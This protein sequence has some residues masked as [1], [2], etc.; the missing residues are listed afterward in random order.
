MPGLPFA[1]VSSSNN[2]VTSI[3]LRS[4]APPS[5][6]QLS[7]RYYKIH[8]DEIRNRLNDARE[9]GKP[10][11]EE[12]FKGLEI[13]GKERLEDVVRWEQWEARGGLKKVNQPPHIKPTAMG[14]SAAIGIKPDSKKTGAHSDRST[15]QGLRLPP[16]P[17][18]DSDGPVMVTPVALPNIPTSLTCKSTIFC[19][20][21]RMFVSEP[22]DLASFQPSWI[23][24]ASYSENILQRHPAPFQTRPERS[25]REVNEAKANRRLEI[26]R[27]CGALDPPLLTNVLT[28][29]EAF[30]AAIQISQPLNDQAWHVLKPRLL[31]QRAYAERRE[32][33]RAAQNQLAQAEQKQRRLQE[34]QLKE[35]RE[36]LDREWESIQIPIRTQITRLAEERI[37]TKWA[38]GK[39]VTKDNCPKFA[40]DVLL[41]V[42]QKFY[43]EIGQEDEA[44]ITVSETTRSDAAD[45]SASRMLILENMKWLF[46]SQ[47]KPLTENFQKELFLCNGCDGN[48][49]FYGLESVVQH[50]AAKHTTSLS[51]GN[52]VV[53][54][55]A[56]WPEHPPFHPEPSVAKAAYYKIP[57][58]LITSLQGPPSRDPELA[59]HFG[60]FGQRASQELNGMPHF[61]TEPYKG[62]YK[63]LYVEQQEQ[64]SRNYSP[65][66][67][68]DYPYFSTTESQSQGFY[69]NPNF[70]HVHP[71][72]Q[73]SHNGVI[74]NHGM[75][76]SGPDY[77]SQTYNPQFS[78]PTY[79]ESLDPPDQKSLSW[80]GSE[81]SA[82]QHAPMPIP[83]RYPNLPL[84][85]TNSTIPY[86]ESTQIQPSEIY[87]HQVEEMARHARD[88]WSATS[89]IK[90]IP[91]SVR[92]FV[93]IHETVYRFK[94]TFL[95][96]PNLAMFIDGLDNN[97]LMRPIRS[98]KGL[99]CKV[100]VTSGGATGVGQFSYT[101]LPVGYRSLHTLPELLN[102]FKTAHVE[103]SR[104]PFDNLNSIKSQSPGTDWK[105][106]MIELPESRLITDLIT[107]PGM[108]DT[109]LE[110]LAKIFPA[111]FP[112][113]LPRMLSAGNAG[114]VPLYTG[115]L[116]SRGRPLQVLM[117]EAYS[118][119]PSRA[120]HQYENQPIPRPYSS[121]RESSQRTRSSEPPGE[122]E[123]DPHRPADLGKIVPLGLPSTH[124]RKSM[125]TSPAVDGQ[126]GKSVPPHHN[127]PYTSSGIAD[128]L[129]PSRTADPLTTFAD[130]EGSK[131]HKKQEEG[132]HHSLSLEG[133][134]ETLSED[135]YD[136]RLHDHR[137]QQK[138]GE[139]EG[140][141]N[142][143]RSAAYSLI[144]E[145]NDLGESLVSVKPEERAVSPQEGASAADEFLDNLASA[146][147]L[148]HTRDYTPADREEN[149]SAVKPTEPSPGRQWHRHN[150]VA[151]EDR[152]GRIGSLNR[153]RR[154]TD[155]PSVP[156][157]TNSVRSNYDDRQ[158]SLN[159]HNYDES[160]RSRSHM[161]RYANGRRI[162]RSSEMYSSFEAPPGTIIREH[163]EMGGD[164]MEPS[165]IR[166]SSFR[167]MRSSQYRSRSRSPRPI[168][169][170]TTYYRTRSPGGRMFEPVYHVRSPSE[171]NDVRPQR[172][173]SYEHPVQDHYE[174]IDQHRPP[175]RQYRQR[176]EYVPVRMGEHASVEPSRF[177]I[178]RSPDIR[179]PPD[180]VRLGRDFDSER[181]YE[182]HG[183]LYHT[184]SRPYHTQPNLG[185]LA[186]TPGYR[187]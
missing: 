42:R 50:Y 23:T 14:G 27:R 107:A 109:K 131:Q 79:A 182:H 100:C 49:K 69:S 43:D 173:I 86:T 115:G 187:Y 124:S 121:F 129:P 145:D 102:H 99:A 117:P 63:D 90:D 6:L 73:I 105:F 22:S 134:V 155:L 108:D 26:E 91:Q 97:G 111:A 47:I 35:T 128:C 160:S 183:Q 136:D 81:P 140:G 161:R 52:Q 104:Q 110:L 64:Q 44:A 118:A 103:S 84:R 1:F 28:H 169:V 72:A 66:L 61:P 176:V 68:Q 65:S 146:S 4:A 13:E 133:A 151:P 177:V 55:R 165:R 39:G 123:Y 60:G 116:D 57:T 101:Q 58:P 130:D 78:M 40:A 143:T 9:L 34:A 92:I 93:V 21:R 154:D 178:A 19:G 88:V 180:Y 125:R 15:P 149:N 53:H 59:N 138:Y 152:G 46:D 112:S 147:N 56:E 162:G 89:G 141:N 179:P 170:G 87:Q 41:Y 122:D 144:S 82:R 16:K 5:T 174:Y 54:W 11:A 184:D 70:G 83:P 119:S 77:V 62:P 24:S 135:R 37:E 45:R 148:S 171:R 106:D 2:Y 167:A 74:Q 96:E 168:P 127:H 8:I 20:H 153:Q 163:F 158:P 98:L 94:V 175:E 120:D 132:S 186:S 157:R 150:E 185:P 48:F 76:S 156:S 126:L 67:T 36:N 18:V 3:A 12:W 85:P 30:Q 172:I 166:D 75:P 95:S 137:I 33:E 114:P 113:P 7:K 80:Y 51:L 71:G 29:M 142:L 38:N 181:M 159:E 164:V 10:S 139:H 32:N 31:A 25:I 17:N